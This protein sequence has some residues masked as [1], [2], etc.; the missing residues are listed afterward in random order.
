MGDDAKKSSMIR[1]LVAIV[2][3]VILLPCSIWILRLGDFGWVGIA[4]ALVPMV[5]VVFGAI[6]IM[7]MIERLDE[8]ERR[9]HLQAL[10]FAGLVTGLGTF[11]YSLMERVGLPPLSLTWVLPIM[12]GLWGVGSRL[13]RAK[14][15]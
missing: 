9:V 12:I 11:A 6:V 8:L 10:A 1:F 4:I 7:Q 2:A 3:Y 5:P 13:A 15:K 14:Y